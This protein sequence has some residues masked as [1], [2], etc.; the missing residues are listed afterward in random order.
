LTE[1]WQA[2]LRAVRALPRGKVASYGQVAALAGLPR[3]A[4]L[5]GRVLANLPPNSKVPWHRVV[6]AR[7]EISL[8]GEAAAR[9]RRLLAGEGVVFMPSGRV[10]LRRHGIVGDGRS[11]P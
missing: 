6:N 10:D 1:E 8:T 7:G 4:R 9:Q 5:V 3:R 2:I 11:T